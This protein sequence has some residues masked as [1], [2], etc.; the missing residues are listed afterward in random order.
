[1]LFDIIRSYWCAIGM[2]LVLKG[3]RKDMDIYRCV[4]ESP[5]EPERAFLFEF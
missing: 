1:V 4:V 3:L 5:F 2:L